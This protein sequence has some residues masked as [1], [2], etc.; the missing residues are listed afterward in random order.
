VICIRD[1]G[2]RNRRPNSGGNARI[3]ITP[4]VDASLRRLNT[5]Y[6]DLSW[7]HVWE[8]RAPVEE[9][10]RALHPRTGVT[11]PA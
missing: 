7:L 2:T 4:A 6:I 11:G 1:L 8:Y 10:R 5:S 3:N 9:V